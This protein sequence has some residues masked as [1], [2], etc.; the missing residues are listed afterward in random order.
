M[1]KTKIAI[2]SLLAVTFASS[3]FAGTSLYDQNREQMINAKVVQTNT[4][5]AAQSNGYEAYA[6]APSQ[7]RAYGLSSAEQRSFDRATEASLSR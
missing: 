3:A 6:Q 4:A 7:Q 5:P 2:A 1:T